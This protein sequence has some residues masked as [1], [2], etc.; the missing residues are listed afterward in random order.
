ME[1]ENDLARGKKQM[2]ED[3]EKQ[4]DA[5]MKIGEI[6]KKLV[7]LIGEYQTQRYCDSLIIRGI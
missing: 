7:E 3:L 1:S 4:K 6:K 2:D 5:V